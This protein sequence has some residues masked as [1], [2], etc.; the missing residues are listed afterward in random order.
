MLF[1]PIVASSL[2]LVAGSAK[3][4]AQHLPPPVIQ[5]IHAAS[6][7]RVQLI[8]GG[9]WR[10]LHA[11]AVD[12]ASLSSSHSG[13]LPG[14]VPSGELEAP[15]PVTQVSQIQV[16]QGSHARTGARIG[17]AVGL[18]LSVLAVAITA[19][20]G[21]VSPSTGQAVRAVVGWTAL[22]AGL[23]AAIGSLSPR[24]TTVYPQ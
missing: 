1:H 8:G 2:L 14:T 24:W 7:I 13:F 23:G 3:M 10:T 11:P 21:W 22:G 19:G 6:K 4:Y 5:E 9:G 15:L 20:D 17:G 16:L 18:G 12:S